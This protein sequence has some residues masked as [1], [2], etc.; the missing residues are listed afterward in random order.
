MFFSG[1]LCSIIQVC[2]RTC[3]RCRVLSRFRAHAGAQV[4]PPPRRREATKWERSM[5]TTNAG[6]TARVRSEYSD[7]QTRHPVTAQT[8]SAGPAYHVVDFKM[9]VQ[10]PCL[11]ILKSS[12]IANFS[13]HPV[14]STQP[15]N[16]I[17]GTTPHPHPR[18]APPSPS[19]RTPPPHSAPPTPLRTPSSLRTSGLEVLCC[20]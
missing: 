4:R 18:S 1:F 8:F 3:E 5:S 11:D 2:S 9:S 19:L 7:Y 14:F 12:P 16:F 13:T 17:L 10:G 20:I 6:W 15:T